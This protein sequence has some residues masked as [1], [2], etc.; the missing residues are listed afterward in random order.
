MHRCYWNG[1][2]AN[3]TSKE[4]KFLAVLPKT[5]KENNNQDQLKMGWTLD[6]AL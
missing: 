2:K 3:I 1:S 5:Y 4:P 6:L